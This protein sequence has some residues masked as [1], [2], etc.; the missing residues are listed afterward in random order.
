MRCLINRERRAA[1]VRALD[2][3]RKL[4]RAAQRHSKRMRGSGCFAHRCPGEG[5]LESRLRA[6][7]YLVDGLSLWRFKENIGWG[8]KQR[9]TPRAVVDNW[10]T[11][12][13]HRANLLNRDYRDVGIGFVTGSPRDADAPAGIYTVNLGYRAR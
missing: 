1:G 11:S 9:G 12:S 10:M 4:Q 7:G 3:S 13:S 8:L 6:S 2:R 5:G